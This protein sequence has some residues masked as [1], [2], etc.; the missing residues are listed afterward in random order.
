MSKKSICDHLSQAFV[1]MA[2]KAEKGDKAKELLEFLSGFFG[3]DAPDDLL[4]REPK[5]LFA[6]GYELWKSSAERAPETGCAAHASSRTPS[7]PSP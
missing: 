6:V 7:H 4:T 1:G 3:A 2:K 5:E